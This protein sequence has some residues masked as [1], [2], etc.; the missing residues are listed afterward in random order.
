M[1]Y[2][3]QAG[4]PDA[5]TDVLSSLHLRGFVFSYSE[6][7]APWA[8]ELPPGKFAYFHVVER[9]GGWLKLN[10]EKEWRSMTGGDLVV[11]PHGGGHIV[12]SDTKTKPLSL[13][14]FLR[15]RDE[16]GLVR[17]GGGGPETHL[18]CGVFEFEDGID[19][20]LI[21]LLPRFIHVRD[22]RA[23]AAGWLESTLRQLSHEARHTRPGSQIMVTRLTDVVFV[24]AVRAWLDGQPKDQGGWL[25]AL[26]DRQIGH[27]LGL[28]HRDPGY[29]WSVESLANKAS[30]S[31]SKF[32]AKFKALVRESPLAYLNRLRLNTAASLLMQGNL[33]VAEVAHQVGYDSET[34]FSSAFKRRYG[35]APGSYRRKSR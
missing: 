2:K 4:P 23:H 32:A 12:G 17:H 1:N 15:L 26:R 6:F 3:Y 31:R 18:V 9:S 10:G 8:L 21:S 16:G 34:A 25:G 20:P 7:S 28:M 24:Q 22:A 5:L 13:K 14:Q 30:M 33:T 29:D 19:N 35:V 11:I 27:A